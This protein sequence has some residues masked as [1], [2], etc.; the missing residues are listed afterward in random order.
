MNPRPTLRK[1][2][3]IGITYRLLL[4]LYPRSFRDSYGHDLALQLQEAQEAGNKVHGRWDLIRN[5]IG[6]RV[7]SVCTRL[8]RKDEL[9]WA[10]TA[11]SSGGQTGPRNNHS[12]V[13]T[14]VE[15]VPS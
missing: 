10:K 1:Q 8:S 2:G 12:N 7:D 6:V 5:A 9:I 13:E 15:G 11:S 14:N 4:R 3:R